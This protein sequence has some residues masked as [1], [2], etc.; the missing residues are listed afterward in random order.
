MN[1]KENYHLIVIGSGAAGMISA[2][3]AVKLGKK[4]LLLEKLSKLGAKLKATGGGKCNLTNTL[5]NDDFMERFGRNG[6]FMSPSLEKFNQEDLRSFFEELGV[7]SHA[8]DGRRVFPITHSSD[9][10][11]KALTS[12]MKELGVRVICS[13]RVEKLLETNNQI[14]GVSTQDN[15]YHASNVIIATGGLGYQ[16]LGADGDGYK[17]ASSLGHKITSLFPAMMPL[18]TK[19]KW[20]AEC[21]ADTISKVI[22]KIDLKKAR[23]LKAVGDLIFTKDGIRGP[24]VLDFAREITPYLETYSEVPC[25]V[26]LTKGINE[27][28]IREHLKKNSNLSISKSLSLLVP[29]AV[30]IEFCKLCDI[31]KEDKFGKIEGVKRDKLIKMLAWTPLTVIGH[32]GFKKAMITRGG[33]SL[34]EINPQ[35]LESKLVKGLYFCGE[36]VDLDGP[37]GGFN[38]QWSFSSGF[39]AGHLG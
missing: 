16:S 3:T 4:V 31:D 19:E 24:V 29:M 9:T 7:K 39:L 18:I 17:L 20:V 10:I 15:N 6:R 11:I 30:G 37:C 21:R 34:K 32:E 28:Q 2:I 33:V 25:L 5:S 26:N 35:T 23:K 14:T 13:Q 1:S 38:L 27:E 8:P 12:K 22:F 36:V